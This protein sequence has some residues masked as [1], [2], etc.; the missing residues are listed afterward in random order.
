MAC[1]PIGVNYLGQKK[2]LLKDIIW[3]MVK[4]RHRGSFEKLS[5][6]IF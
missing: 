6:A 4:D 1:E 2:T 3:P 5:I